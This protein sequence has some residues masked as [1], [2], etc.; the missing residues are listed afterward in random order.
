MKGRE[1]GGPWF[2]S[3]ISQKKGGHF[4]ELIAAWATWDGC[5][6]IP[7]RRQHGQTTDLTFSWVHVLCPGADG[8]SPL[9]PW[10]VMAARYIENLNEYGAKGFHERI[11]S[12]RTFLEHYLWPHKFFDPLKF[13]TLPK[14]TMPPPVVGDR[15]QVHSCRAG[16]SIPTTSMILLAGLSSTTTALHSYEDG[17]YVALPG[18]TQPVTAVG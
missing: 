7:V 16:S 11:F 18:H 12:L 5:K 4:R 9:E 17:V 3:I 1:R 2:N 15:R 6:V 14:G 13:L 10:R 8:L